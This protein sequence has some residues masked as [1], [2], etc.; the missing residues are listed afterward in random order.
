MLFY[1][2]ICRIYFCLILFKNIKKCDTIIDMQKQFNLRRN[3]MELEKIAESFYDESIKKNMPLDYSNKEHIFACRVFKSISYS[4]WSDKIMTVEQKKEYLDEYNIENL[5]NMLTELIK[6]VRE[7]NINQPI[8]PR[9]LT[10]VPSHWIFYNQKIKHTNQN[11]EMLTIFN[12]IKIFS[13]GELKIGI[14]E[15]TK[16]ENGDSILEFYE[17]SFYEQ[18]KC[19]VLLSFK[20]TTNLSTN[21]KDQHIFLDYYLGNES[22]E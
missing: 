19:Y 13:S 17:E 11:D 12:T 21:Q 4:I 2:F 18:D 10:S 9:D 20:E 5:I 7:Y 1:L 16:K 15:G 6:A 8:I 14:Q 3:I 22:F